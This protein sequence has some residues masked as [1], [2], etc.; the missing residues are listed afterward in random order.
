MVINWRNMGSML[1]GLVLMAPASASYWFTAEQVL[2]T[3]SGECVRTGDW[4]PDAAI[5]GCDG[6]SAPATT[7]APPPAVVVP[8]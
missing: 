4:A 6:M 5:V 1:I 7:S 2:R 8:N 3:S